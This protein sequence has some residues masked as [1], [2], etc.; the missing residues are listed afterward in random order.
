[1]TE[2]KKIKNEETDK[3]AVLLQDFS[4]CVY[5]IL[6]IVKTVIEHPGEYKELDNKYVTLLMSLDDLKL[7]AYD[8]SFKEK[9]YR[10]PT[11][12]IY[13]PYREESD[14]KVLYKAENNLRDLLFK[15]QRARKELLKDGY[16][17]STGIRDVELKK[18]LEKI[19]GK[20]IQ[21]FIPSKEEFIA[22]IEA[23]DEDEDEKV[24]V[25]THIT[26][27]Y[28]DFVFEARNKRGRV[29][30][31]KD[32]KWI[33]LGGYHTRTYK[34]AKYI[35]SPS[36]KSTL[37]DDVF[38]SIRIKTDDK[39]EDF[40]KNTPRAYQLKKE[41]IQQSV[42]ELQKDGFLRGHLNQPVFDDQKKKVVINIK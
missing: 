6:Q 10:L 28:K 42:D 22:N 18:I 29:K 14:K 41:K 2:L 32:G 5:D 38:E 23:K 35:F 21:T 20:N 39:I 9:D 16:K 1:M 19:S 26:K 30:F 11:D 37:V 27:I 3:E 31:K 25:S 36:S 7:P 15:V 33:D 13:L 17:P 8:F 4:Q 40:Q 24:K 12:L 34:L